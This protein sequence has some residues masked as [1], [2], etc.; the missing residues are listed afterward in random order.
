MF[1]LETNETTQLQPNVNISYALI[2]R[3]SKGDASI[4]Q[5]SYLFSVLLIKLSRLVN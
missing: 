4:D 1:N 5:V 2:L 3:K